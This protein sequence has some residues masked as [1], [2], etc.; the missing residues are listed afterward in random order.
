MEYECSP[1]DSLL[2]GSNRLASDRPQF[3]TVADKPDR[4]AVMST[5]SR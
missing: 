1:A 4:I 5:S 3:D 2:L